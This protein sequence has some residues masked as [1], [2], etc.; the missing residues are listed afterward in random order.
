MTCRTNYTKSEWY[1]NAGYA[2]A[3]VL[4]KNRNL[5]HIVPR[6]FGTHHLINELYKSNWPEWRQLHVIHLL[7]NHRSYLD[8]ESPIKEFD[9]KNI[10]TFNYTY[11]EMCRFVL[12]EIKNITKQR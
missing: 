10:L 12:N 2:S 11:G 9:E 1:W 6:L 3:K 5:A 7:I 4:L 8:K